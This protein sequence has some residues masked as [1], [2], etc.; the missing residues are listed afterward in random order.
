MIPLLTHV[1]SEVEGSEGFDPPEP[2][3]SAGGGVMNEDVVRGF[4]LVPPSEP[5]PPEMKNAK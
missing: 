5:N 4:S 1:L 2:L 3:A